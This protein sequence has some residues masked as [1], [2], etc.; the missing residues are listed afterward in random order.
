[1]NQRMVSLWLLS[2]GIQLPFVKCCD[3]YF[4][5]KLSKKLGDP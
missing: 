3:P 5:S 2:Q 1:M 4:F